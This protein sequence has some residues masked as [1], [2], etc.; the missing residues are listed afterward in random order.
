LHVDQIVLAQLLAF[1]QTT[2]MPHQRVAFDEMPAAPLD[3]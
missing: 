2:I 3:E 1:L